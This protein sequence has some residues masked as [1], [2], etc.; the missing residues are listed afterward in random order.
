LPL[1]PELYDRTYFLS[2]RC[3][4]YEAFEARRGV[5]RIK[6]RQVALLAPEPG[7]RILDA[8][9]GR[10]EV[11][12][13]CARAGA[14]VAGIDYSEAA[15]EIARETLAEVAG[16]EI[17]LGSVVALPWPDATFDRVLWADVVE[18]LDAGDARRALG[19]F[20]RV[21]RP[22][23]VLLV[24]TSP[25]RVFRRLTWPLARPLLRAAGL[26]ANVERVDAWLADALRYHVNEQ[27]LHGLRR[28][29]RRA[30]FADVSA[31]LDPDARRGGEHHLTAGLDSSRLVVSV[32]ALTAWRPVRLLLSNDLYA[33]GR[34]R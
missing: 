6:G 23:G 3:E 2:D 4:G 28:L 25:N 11:L 10:G 7:V 22:G 21:L 8:G 5:S 20:H 1:P 12:L 14:A 31:W 29:V 27:T 26:S 9:C 13:A 18:H 19:E 17:V 24:H 32:S 30:G 34:R 33:V 15:I 16:T